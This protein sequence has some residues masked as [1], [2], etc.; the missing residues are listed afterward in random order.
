MRVNKL[1]KICLAAA[2]CSAALSAGTA[3][4]AESKTVYPASFERE[5]TFVDKDGEAGA[6]YDYSVG[7]GQL[8]FAYETGVYSLTLGDDGDKTLQT[9]THVCTVSNVEVSGKNIYV[10]GSDG[11]VYLYPDKTTSDY[12][13][14]QSLSKKVI[15]MESGCIYMLDGDELDFRADSEADKVVVGTGFSLAKVYDDVLY[16]VKDNLLY[17]ISAGVA[18]EVDLSYT[19]YSAADKIYSAEA[20]EILKSDGYTVT[21]GKIADGT[22]Y[23]QVDPDKLGGTYFTQ[24]KTSKAAGEISCLILAKCDGAAV[25][26]LQ[27]GLYVTAAESVTDSVYTAPDNDWSGKTAYVTQDTEVYS[28]LYM[29][30][31]TI[32]DTL[33][34]ADKTALTVTEKIQLDYVD[35][36]FYRITY[37][38]GDTEKSGFIA[39]GYLCEYSFAADDNEP[40]DSGFENYSDKSNAVT[41]CLAVAIVGLVLVAVLYLF[42]VATKNDKAYK[43]K[44]A[45]K[46]SFKDLDEEEDE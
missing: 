21:I 34:A 22:Y 27:G 8:V 29:C 23:T 32:C 6:P 31:S 16:A 7:D 14:F 43:K 24:I 10:K 36:T 5:L 1:F 17:K 38:S 13:D 12:D 42:A 45:K 33:T 3:F 18:E 30:S 11:A 41:V 19:D 35:G 39:A 46:R 15:T 28:S 20:L 25:V 37:K 40:T 2:V 44:R 9:Y 26:A 4:G